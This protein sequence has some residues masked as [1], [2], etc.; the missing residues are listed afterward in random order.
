MEASSER[1]LSLSTTPK[2]GRR[3]HFGD[4]AFKT[5][6]T[7]IGG[8]VLV[9]FSVMI[10]KTVIAA[11][12]A[13]SGEFGQLITSSAWAPTLNKFGAAGFIYGTLVTSSIAFLLA[14][15]AS[16]GVAVFL[17]EIAPRS[18][19]KGLGYLVEL[20]AAIPSVIFGLWGLLVLVPWLSSTF[21][22]PISGTL[23]FIPIFSGP[24]S[25][26]SY[27]SAGV[28]LAI[29]IVPIVTAVSREVLAAIPNEQR[30]AALALG[31]TRWEM[32]RVAVIPSARSGLAGA[33]MLGFGRAV[34]ETIAV[35]L[36]IGGSAQIATS[37]FSPGY[38]MASV[39]ANE[40]PES[41]GLHT[42]SLIAIGVL[43]FFLTMAINACA[44]FLVNRTRVAS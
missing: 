37:V 16:L 4:P 23:G 10:V 25:G 12:P 1:S 27:A 3:L 34:G 28:V 14:V 21:W 30:E 38:T 22:G 35:A 15:P 20:L 5:S 42:Q 19:G 2:R 33:T 9:I 17:N 24:A 8:S 11:W 41:F 43:M 44:R 29:M 26:L 13:L 31:A 40:F 18:L 6:V 32:I 7:I 39:I 36:I